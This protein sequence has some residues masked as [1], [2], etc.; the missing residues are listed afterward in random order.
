[1]PAEI[2]AGLADS[3]FT[4]AELRGIDRDNGLQLVPKFRT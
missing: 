1:M 2:A 3:G 4:A